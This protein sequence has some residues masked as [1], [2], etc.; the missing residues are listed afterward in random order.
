[1][2]PAI[3]TAIAFAAA[4]VCTPSPAVAQKAKSRVTPLIVHPSAEPIGS[5]LRMSHERLD[6]STITR[7]DTSMKVGR[8]LTQG[9]SVTKL[10]MQKDRI[11]PDAERERR[12]AVIREQDDLRHKRISVIFD[13]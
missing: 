11:T 12:Q 10:R 9:E 8:E 3:L 1:M 2:H 13:D 7:E 4:I 5:S 6:L